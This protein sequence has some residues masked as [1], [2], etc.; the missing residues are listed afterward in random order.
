MMVFVVGDCS[1]AGVDCF[2]RCMLL[3]CMK[4]IFMDRKAKGKVEGKCHGLVKRLSWITYW[5]RLGNRASTQSHHLLDMPCLCLRET[6]K[7]ETW[8]HRVTW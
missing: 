8:T 1:D 3:E 4:G 7:E 2:C 5:C 6:A